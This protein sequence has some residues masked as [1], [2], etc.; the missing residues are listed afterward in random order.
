MPEDDGG[1][2]IPGDA[3]DTAITTFTFVEGKRRRGDA[4]ADYLYSQSGEVQQ[5]TEAELRLL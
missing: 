1:E 2:T 4:A 5:V 3:Q